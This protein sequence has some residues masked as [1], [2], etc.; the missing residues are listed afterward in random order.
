MN[1]DAWIGKSTETKD[2]LTPGLLRRYL[3]TVGGDPDQHIAPL[4]IHWCLGLPDARLHDLGEDGHPLK[5]GFLPPIDLPRR[6]WASSRVEFKRPLFE[7]ARIRRGSEVISV[8]AKE[9]ASGNLAFIDVQHETFAEEKLAITEV[10]T[11]VYRQAP[12]APMTLTASSNKAEESDGQTIIPTPQLLFRYS[13]LTFNT[14]RIHYDEPYAKTVEGYPA[15]VVHGP[16]MAS[17]LL[18]R[19][20]QAFGAENISAFSFRGRAPAYCGQ[21]LRFVVGAADCGRADLFIHGPDGG[22]VMSSKIELH[23]N[24]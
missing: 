17:Q 5:G 12:T 24:D 20:S 9:G 19:A 1:F 8:Q 15:L 13:A 11:I 21:Q 18:C 10:Q 16:L 2:V 7:G 14:H 23:Q 3:A 22:S 6:M 4:G